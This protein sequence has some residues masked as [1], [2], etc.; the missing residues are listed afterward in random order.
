MMRVGILGLGFMGKTHFNS[1][2]GVE[3]TDVVA[4]CD[5]DAKKFTGGEKVGNLDTGDQ[6]LDLSGVATYT[7]F[8]KMI[9]E[10]ELDAVSITLPTYMHARFTIKAL[11]AGLHVLCEKPMALEIGQCQDMIAAAEKSGKILQVGHCIRF[12]PEYV[13]TKELIDSGQYGKVLAASFRRLSATPGW[14]WDNWITSS[15][16]AGGALMDLHIHDSDYIQYVFG[17]PEAVYTSGVKIGSES[18]CHVATNYKYRDEKVITAEG[19]WLM[20]DS[21]GFEMSFN[22]VLEKATIVFDCTREPAFK[23]CPA[24][25][26]PFS[27]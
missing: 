18:Y 17:M 2:K 8:D 20:A 25:G 1:F 16:K 5:A 10:A 23:V 26:E 24:E 7:D 19:G 4:V 6:A 13:K 12:W 15:D 21:F 3:G 11:E 22:I 27:P 14:S 9:A